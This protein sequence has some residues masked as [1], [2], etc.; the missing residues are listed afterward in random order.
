MSV[1]SARRRFCRASHRA[2]TDSGASQTQAR[3]AFVRR[4]IETICIL[5]SITLGNIGVVKIVDALLDAL[6]Y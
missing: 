1:G 4:V 3:S 6:H 2:H 5:F